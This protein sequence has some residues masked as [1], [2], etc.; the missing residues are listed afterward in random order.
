MG[1]TNSLIAELWGIIDGLVLA[2]SMRI[3][4]I[5]VQSDAKEAIGLIVEEFNDDIPLLPLI[6]DCRRLLID[7]QKYKLRHVF[8][9]ANGVAYILAKEVV[10]IKENYVILVE[11]TVGCLSTLRDYV[12]GIAINIIV[13]S[14][15]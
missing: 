10:S 7:F 8:R 5:H 14:G 15:N 4:N 11:P 3:L 12:C 1:M 6:S 13:T 2:R 9:E